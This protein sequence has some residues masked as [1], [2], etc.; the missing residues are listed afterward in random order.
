MNNADDI[1]PAMR[2][3]IVEKAVEMGYTRSRRAKGQP[4]LAV[5]ICNMAYEAPQ[6]F[7]YEL[8]MGFRKGAEP[9]GYAVDLIP[10]DRQL[11]E[12]VRYDAYMLQNNYTGGF[13]LGL[14]LTDPWLE[15]CRTCTTP[16]ALYDNH[17]VENPLVTQ[18]GVDNIDGMKLA[19]SYLKSLGHEK[20]GYLGNALGSYVYRQRYDAFL[21]AMAEYGVD[22]DLV[23]TE[24]NVT[25][26]LYHH[27][28]RLLEKGCTAIVCSHDVLASSALTY[29]RE[30]G[31]SVPRDVSIIGFDDIPLC[32]Y[33]LPPLTTI[34]QDRTQIGKCAYSALFSQLRNIPVSGIL[35][36]PQLVCRSSCAPLTKA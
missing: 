35:M 13:F 12:S 5:F 7:G 11:Q 15:E 29:C 19:V 16:T 8:I 14:T 20:I 23:G 10:L 30:L 33:T 26:C 9:D 6:D 17:V 21:A 1:S 2:N 18:V 32:E 36:H 31:K 34:R 25:D 22:P 28:P 3:A 27:L 4:K 24:L